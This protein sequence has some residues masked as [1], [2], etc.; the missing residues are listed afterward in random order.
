MNNI[1]LKTS[2]EVDSILQ[3]ACQDYFTI[4]NG[5]KEEIILLETTPFISND[6]EYQASISS[7]ESWLKLIKKSVYKL[8]LHALSGDSS[9]EGWEEN[10]RKTSSD[11][12]KVAI[13]DAIE[14]V[15][16][17]DAVPFDEELQWDSIAPVITNI[18]E[19]IEVI[20]KKKMLRLPAN[21]EN[22]GDTS[23][24]RFLE[25]AT[26]RKGSKLT[27]I[28]KFCDHIEQDF[29]MQNKKLN[30]DHPPL[31]TGE[32]T[33][34]T[35]RF[36]HSL[37]SFSSTTYTNEL[38]GYLPSEELLKLKNAEKSAAE[39]NKAI[40]KKYSLLLFH[41]FKADK[42]ARN[43][44]KF[45]SEEIKAKINCDCGQL[46]EM[47][48]KQR[49]DKERSFPTA[50]KATIDSM[51]KKNMIDKT[52]HSYIEQNIQKIVIDPQEMICYLSTL[53]ARIKDIFALLQILDELESAK[54]NLG[55][56]SITEHNILVRRFLIALEGHW[57]ALQKNNYIQQINS[58]LRQFL[59]TN[60]S[61]SDF[62]AL[63]E[64]KEILNNSGII[65]QLI[66]DFVEVLEKYQFY[67]APFVSEE[68]ER[69]SLFFENLVIACDVYIKSTLLK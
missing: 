11:M 49:D 2:L 55:A 56:K 6:E 22:I 44:I 8:K 65:I 39:I 34:Q 43:V 38:P 42:Q 52:A 51:L 21:C 58:S 20:C 36:F 4:I 16:K 68:E 61:H 66:A 40:D 31:N 24:K 3:G 25:Q 45:F 62:T 12:T 29:K 1:W 13:R 48:P 14:K 41:S 46:M 50:M 53:K 37:Q 27:V 28:L 5:V 18:R 47:V 33:E 15:A 69:K 67:K 63:M 57:E 54:I 32:I 19:S 7:S 30:N 64:S 23:R 60:Q 35:R 59:Q 17:L 26:Q 9:S 10:W